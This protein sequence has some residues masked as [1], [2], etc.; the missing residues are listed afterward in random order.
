MPLLPFTKIVTEYD[1]LAEAGQQVVLYPN[2][3]NPNGNGGGEIPGNFGELDFR[4]NN[5]PAMSALIT[6]GVL[7]ADLQAN[8]GVSELTYI[9]SMGAPVEYTIEGTPGIR[10]ALEDEIAVY[11]NQIVGYF[12]HNAATENGNNATYQNV[13]IRFGRL[14]SVELNGQPKELIVQPLPYNGGGVIIDENAPSS[15][16]LIGRIVLV[17]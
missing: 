11:T 8:L 1:P 13:G 9:D 15:N 10:A 7:A 5:T 6:S 14:I 12:V 2:Y 17:E 4:G 16:G 3:S